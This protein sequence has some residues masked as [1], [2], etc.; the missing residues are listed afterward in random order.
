M[1]RVMV[2]MLAIA[3]TL[4]GCATKAP[5]A[6]PMAVLTSF[7]RPD[8]PQC[9]FTR[10][11]R[12]SAGFSTSAYAPPPRRAAMKTY[13]A[14]Q[15]VPL[16]RPN[17]RLCVVMIRWRAAHDETA[18]ALLGFDVSPVDAETVLVT[19]AY[20]RLTESALRDHASTSAITT[21][22]RLRDGDQS[23][24]FSTTLPNVRLTQGR[25]ING[26]PML[27]SWRDAATHFTLSL[28]VTE[29]RPGSR[30]RQAQAD[31]ENASAIDEV[32]RIAEAAAA[33]AYIPPS[34]ARPLV[35]PP[36]A[37]DAARP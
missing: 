11:V 15:V 25:A 9:D 18:L 24:T 32:Q 4:S 35:P 20:V 16:P 14:G 8:E 17:E 34:P 37:H 6:E 30:R 31:R 10:P 5:P 29:W 21:R 2:A 27:M 19:P 13:G 22:I 36:P 33:V 3:T 26:E 7:W 23:Q 1:I 12:L 28:A